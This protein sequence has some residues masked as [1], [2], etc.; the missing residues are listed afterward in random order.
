MQ[1]PERVLRIKK[2]APCFRAFL[3]LHFGSCH[4]PVVLVRAQT[5]GSPRVPAPDSEVPAPQEWSM[6]DEKQA[7]NVVKHPPVMADRPWEVSGTL[8]HPY[9]PS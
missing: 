3:R 8:K 1:D 5:P 4:L 9:Q 6:S 7:F 2:M